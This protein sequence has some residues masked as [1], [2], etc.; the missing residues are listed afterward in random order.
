MQDTVDLLAPLHLA[1]ETGMEA[2]GFKREERAFHPH[3]TLGRVKSQ[4]RIE[5]L[6]R[7]IESITFESQPVTINEITLMKSTLTPA[8]SIYTPLNIIPLGS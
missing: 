8:G 4:R 1:I 6:L 2:L 7:R 3:V 5:T